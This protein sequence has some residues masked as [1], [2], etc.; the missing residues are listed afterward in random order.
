MPTH[1]DALHE[2]LEDISWTDS[3]PWRESLV[4]TSGAPTEVEDI[5]NDLERE[6]A[7]YNQ[8]R[9]LCVLSVLGEGDSDESSCQFWGVCLLERTCSCGHSADR[10]LWPRVCCLLLHTIHAP[11]S[12][13]AVGEP[14][15]D[16]E[17]HSCW[18]ALAAPARLLRRCVWLAARAD[19]PAAGRTLRSLWEGWPPVLLPL[20]LHTHTHSPLYTSLAH[21]ACTPTHSLP[22][23]T[24]TLFWGPLSHQQNRDGKE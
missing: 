4:I 20:C 22:T 8:A 9:V 12:P 2:K 15:G 21:S 14:G 3:Q 19:G 18:H 11:H 24:R 7:F 6:L 5:D 16:S 23:H 13:G 1:T 10:T 17:V